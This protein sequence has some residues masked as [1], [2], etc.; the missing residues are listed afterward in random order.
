GHVAVADLVVHEVHV[1][2]GAVV[3]PGS[4]RG[5]AVDRVPLAVDGAIG[6]ACVAA[7][8]R[9]ARVSRAVRAEVSEGQVVE[10]KVATG[11]DAEFGVAAAGAGGQAG[12]ADLPFLGDPGGDPLKRLPRVG[13]VPDPARVRRQRAGDA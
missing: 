1:V 5:I 6:H 3:E 9:R 13:R 12:N 11:V 7:D 10:V 2:A 4:G 8:K